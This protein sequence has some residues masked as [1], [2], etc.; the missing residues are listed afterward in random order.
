[1]RSPGVFEKKIDHSSLR[2]K[3]LLIAFILGSLVILIRLFTWQVI[4]APQLTKIA[5]SQHQVSSVIP[6]Q[7]GAIL[8]SDDFPLASSEEAFLVWASLP[9]IKDSSLVASRLAP[10]LVD[11]DRE[12]GKE[13][14]E[15]EEERIKNLLSK[16]DVVWVPLKHKVNRE[17]RGEIL[18]LGL[19]G[20]G[21]DPEEK[22]GY[23]EGSMSAHLLGFVGSNAAGQDQGYFGLEGYYDLTLS[24]AR[25]ERGWEKDASGNPILLGS[26]RKITA[27]DGLSLKT[28]ID[29]ALQF[30]I[31]RRLKEG[32]LRYGASS[33]TTIVL[34]P[35]D[36]A[37]LAMASLPSYDPA[38]FSK[39]DKERFVNPAVAESFEPG[40]IFKILIMAGALDAGVIE[41]DDRCDECS[42]PR[43]IA[44]YTLKTWNEKYYP[45]TTAREIIQHSDNV[46]MI[47]VG[48][49]LGID[50]LY[51]YLRK[52]GIGEATGIDLQD[53]SSPRLRERDK[54]GLIDLAT[55]SFGQ[56]IAITPIQMVR[57]VSA[58]A[59]GGNLPTP[60]VVDKLVG[61]GWEQDIKPKIDREVIS[62]EAAEKITEMMVNAVEAGEAKWTKVPGFKIAGKT[63]TAQI[64]VSGHYDQDK[65]IASFVGFAPA[66][67]PRFVMLVTLRG[68]TSSPWAS[69]SA[70][71]LWFTIAKDIFP[72]LGIQPD[73]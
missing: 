56:G 16:K 2:I 44:E 36:G 26:F 33:G 63:G 5:R 9:E 59:N 42:G 14:I 47:W 45:N 24:G 73:R 17:V 23:P 54:W 20:I 66:D 34:R 35:S 19:E 3:L 72:H 18:K 38:R 43:H 11:E 61:V 70:A 46:G 1:M 53:E 8:S 22:R 58:I 25:G 55:A 4:K 32:L 6:A 50:R 57:A 15:A 69:E 12:T 10:L 52:F 62:K 39:F 48:E 65:T 29:R 68:P 37:V 71:P 67:N 64:P 28:N 51:E 7:R 60:Q 13:L 21:F 31:E 30:I 40:S 49:K 41:P 27:L